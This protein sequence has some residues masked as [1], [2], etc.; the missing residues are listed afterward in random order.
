MSQLVGIIANQRFTGHT[1]PIM[2]AAVADG[3]SVLDREYVQRAYRDVYDAGHADNLKLWV[4]AGLPKL[5]NSGG[6]DYVPKLYDLSGN[7]NNGVQTTEANQPVWSATGMT[8]DGSNDYINIPSI[9]IFNGGGTF[10]EWININSSQTDSNR[11]F[12]KTTEAILFC[13]GKNANNDFK[14][15]FQHRFSTT[16]GEWRSDN[17]VLTDSIFIHIAITYDN[18]STS[19]NPLFYINGSSVALTERSTPVGTANKNTNVILL[20]NREDTLRPYYGTKNDI[21][22]YNA[23]LAEAEIAKIVNETS[24]RYA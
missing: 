9:N 10:M 21:R 19:N 5:R 11:L 8:F 15:N 4:C 12:E 20:G 18:S 24:Y 7:G 2:A 17:N 1:N 14:L 22:I 16:T 3:G 23:I 6:V 13:T